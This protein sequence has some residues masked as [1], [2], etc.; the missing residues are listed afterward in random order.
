MTGLGP[1]YNWNRWYDPGNGRYW[2]SDPILFNAPIVR[3]LANMG[4]TS[5]P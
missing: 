4:A 2:S 5:A 3:A 1:Y